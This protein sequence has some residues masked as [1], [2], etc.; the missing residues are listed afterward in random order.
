M[1]QWPRPVTHSRSTYVV[2]RSAYVVTHNRSAYAVNRSTYVVTHNR[3]TYVVT[4][5][6]STYVVTY[7]VTE[8][9]HACEYMPE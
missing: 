1:L 5:N 6:R 9:L 7:V 3:S 4:H 2:N 8:R